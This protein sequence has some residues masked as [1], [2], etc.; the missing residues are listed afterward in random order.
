MESVTGTG[1]KLVCV[2]NLKDFSCRQ[3]IFGRWGEERER[4]RVGLGLFI[5]HKADWR[6]DEVGESL[7]MS[8]DHHH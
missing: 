2:K 6:W 4:E 1:E 5:Y 8:D 7:P 3:V